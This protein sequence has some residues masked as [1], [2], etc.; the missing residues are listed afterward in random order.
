MPGG[1]LGT[2]QPRMPAPLHA[3]TGTSSCAA[4]KTAVQLCL[5][6][7]PALAQVVLVCAMAGDP[8]Q[9]VSAFE[10]SLGHD[11]QIQSN[12]SVCW[13]AALTMRVPWLQNASDKAQHRRSGPQRCCSVGVHKHTRNTKKP[14][15]H[16]Q[17]HR[18]LLP[19]PRAFRR[20]AGLRA[21]TPQAA[22]AGICA[23]AG[24]PRVRQGRRTQAPTWLHWPASR[25][26]VESSQHPSQSEKRL[27][28][29]A[30]EVS[31][32]LSTPSKN[33]T[34]I[35]TIALTHTQTHTRT[36]PPTP[37]TPT[38][39]TTTTPSPTGAVLVGKTDRS[40]CSATQRA[41]AGPAPE[42]AAA[43]GQKVQ[44]RPGCC[45]RPANKSAGTRGKATRTP[46]SNL[47]PPPKPT[48]RCHVR[49]HAHA[50]AVVQSGAAL[51][52]Q[53]RAGTQ[54]PAWCYCR[55][56]AHPVPARC[57]SDDGCS[58]RMLEPPSSTA[59]S[60]TAALPA[61]AP[62]PCVPPATPC[63]AGSCSA[64]PR[65]GLASVA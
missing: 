48:P 20:Q 7:V 57:C 38:T 49:Q 26:S 23:A 28:Q 42:G 27:W 63:P 10:G 6:A 19:A 15:T 25:R 65:T 50:G 59:S 56:Q 1:A 64:A 52:Q 13:N 21:R 41:A 24:T 54:P 34:P 29:P 51:L 31:S 44:R 8:G 40:R 3:K 55:Q 35:H 47:P 58:S 62:P 17:S 61:V 45:P 4:S 36:T 37:T 30:G 14:R 11:R 39:T 32:P 53:R 18:A 9:P 12:L 22:G 5:L 2:L 60:L 43:P 16:P 46:Q 33:H